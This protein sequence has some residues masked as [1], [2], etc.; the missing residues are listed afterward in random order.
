MRWRR[1]FA[2]TMLLGVA[3]SV[4]GV[5]ATVADSVDDWSTTG[6]QGEKNWFNG[7][8]NLTADDDQVYG[9]AD[10]T[11]FTNDGSLSTPAIDGNH[12][13]GTKWDLTID[14][15]P[16]TEM[17]QLNA[18]P[19]G[20]NSVPNE[21]HWVI[22]RW[23]SNYAG[24][25]SLITSIADANTCEP[26]GSSIYLFHNGE[27]ISSSGTA[28]PNPLKATTG[29]VLK[30]GDFIDLAL[31]PEGIDGSRGDGCDG[32]DF[33]LT[34]TDEKPLP[35]LPPL[36]QL[37][38]AIADSSR[39]WSSAGT[40]G[41]KG[42]TN[43]WFNLTADD[44]GEYSAG[45]FS[46]FV[47]DNSGDPTS[48][49][50]NHWSGTQW[51]LT[52]D[53][54]PW[55]ELAQETTHPN[56]ENSPPNEEHWTIR[57]WTA[58]GIEG[59]KSLDVTWEMAKTNLNGGGVGGALYVNGEL[60]DEAVIA[61]NDGTGVVR[62]HRLSIKNG[63]LIDLVLTPEN[64]DESRGDGSDGSRNKLTIRTPVALGDF[65]GDGQFDAIDMNG[66]TYAVLG[67][68]TEPRFDVNLDGSVNAADRDTWINSIKK[69]YVGDANMDGEFNT[70][71]FVA[72]F[73]RGEYEDALIANSSWETGDWNGDRE[74]N[75]GDFIAAFQAGGFEA[76]PRAAV[77]AVPEPASL[78]WMVGVLLLMLRRRR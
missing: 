78:G 6:T 66:L 9:V 12:W 32:T 52:G 22:R 71:D 55:T 31:S 59:T 50:G 30:V 72:V 43:G 45:D 37:P 61:G 46:P 44:N 19:N 14:P 38:S 56:G 36:P 42:W 48:I 73:Q 7:Y 34:V 10:F 47:N 25:A 60:V 17:G 18:H 70:G 54:G 21:E 41:E 5:A 26:T 67:E 63:D 74:F 40:Q 29:R 16:W 77:S 39:D 64:A 76:G 1:L 62:T 3:T 33:R 15:G 11:E 8:F 28:L 68:N 49:D 65:N 53:P 57:R 69:T 23:V 20:T 4:P 58:S 24:D 27:L 51:D 2:V 35:P 13:D 75:T